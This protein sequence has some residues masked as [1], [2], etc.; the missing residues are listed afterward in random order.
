MSYANLFSPIT[1]R[2]VTFPNRIHRTSMVSGLTTEDGMVTDELIKRYIR[3]AKGGVGGIVGP[4]GPHRRQTHQQPKNRYH[5]H[6]VF[7][8][9]DPSSKNVPAQRKT[10]AHYW[11]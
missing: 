2:G 11:L 7:P 5:H 1:M 3:E 4:H 10:S 9:H 8:I 6:A